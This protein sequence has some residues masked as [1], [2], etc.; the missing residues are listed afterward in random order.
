M[1]KISSLTLTIILLLGLLGCV[2][3]DPPVD[4][5]SQVAE[6]AGASEVTSPHNVLFIECKFTPRDEIDHGE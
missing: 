5:K 1:K 3:Q 2:Q 4:A 6:T